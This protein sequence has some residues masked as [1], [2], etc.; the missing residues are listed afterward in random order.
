MALKRSSLEKSEKKPVQLSLTEVQRRPRQDFVLWYEKI[1]FFLVDLNKLE[2][3]GR[4][5]KFKTSLTFMTHS[6]GEHLG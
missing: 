3:F 6:Q 5:K 1:F 4:G 2:R